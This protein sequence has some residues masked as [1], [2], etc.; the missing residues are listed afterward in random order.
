VEVFR[1]AIAV[2]ERRSMFR[3]K[4]WAEPQDYQPNP[5]DKGSAKPPDIKQVWF[6]GVHAD[7]GG[8]YPEA[9]SGPAKYPLG[10]MIDEAVLHGLYISRPMYDHLVLGHALQGGK[11]SYTAPSFTAKLHNSMTWGWKPLE[12]IPKRV[13][14]RDRP[15]RRSLFGWYLPLCEPRRIDPGARVHYSVYERV[16]ADPT[17]RPVNLPPKGQ[18]QIEG[19]LPSAATDGKAAP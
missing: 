5:F 9:E 7:I 15:Q 14:S 18:V 19:S 17:Y 4:R 8:G 16:D 10:W 12:V 2:D 6:A 1:Q 13:K 11:R 3:I